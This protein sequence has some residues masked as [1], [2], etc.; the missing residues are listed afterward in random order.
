MQ[1]EMIP[2]NESNH[3]GILFSNESH[4]VYF[5]SLDPSK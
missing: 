1:V 4:C 2:W 3:E 5:M